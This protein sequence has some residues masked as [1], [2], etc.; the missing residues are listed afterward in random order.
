MKQVIQY[1]IYIVKW[2]PWLIPI[3]KIILS[4]V[5]KIFRR[6]QKEFSM[7]NLSKAD[8]IK[9]VAA[10]AET[11][12][13]KLFLTHVEKIIITHLTDSCHD[14]WYVEMGQILADIVEQCS[15][16]VIN[17]FNGSSNIP[18]EW[19]ASTTQDKINFAIEVLIEQGALIS[20]IFLP[21]PKT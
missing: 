13:W 15:T 1:L 2:I 12:E 6:R 19:A 5:G 4:M 9:L 10:L 3:F 16:E 7:I 21:K 20:G 17:A 14:V 8:K 18:A 11:E